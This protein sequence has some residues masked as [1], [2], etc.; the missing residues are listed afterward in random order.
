FFFDRSNRT[1]RRLFM[2]SNIYL[3]V[4]MLLLVVA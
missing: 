3:V 4:V 2:T 1:A